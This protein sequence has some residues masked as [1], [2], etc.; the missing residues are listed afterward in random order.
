MSICK[1]ATNTFIYKR[2]CFQVLK[3]ILKYQIYIYH[4]QSN[5][6]QDEHPKEYM[7]KG[8]YKHFIKEAMMITKCKKS[9]RLVQVRK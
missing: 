7:G 9:H 2:K 3:K 6:K 5:K 8:I 1:V 4:L